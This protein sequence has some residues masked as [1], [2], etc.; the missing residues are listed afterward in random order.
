MPKKVGILVGSLRKDSFTR[1]VAEATAK[2]FPE[3]VQ[4]EFVEIGHLPF[5]NQDFETPDTAPE[6]HTAFR[7]KIEGYDGFLFATP[8]YNR[9]H[10][11]VLKNAIDIASR[12]YG[13]NKWNGQPF[14]LVSVSIGAIGGFGANH[15]LRQ[16]FAFLI[17]VPAQQPEAYIGNVSSLLGDAGLLPEDSIALLLSLV[18]ALVAKL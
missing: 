11:P 10:T 8:E 7:K 6:S 3:G 14:A 17:M 9:S 2:L 1:K 18:D 15:H 5:F 13:E 4:A 16:S 12:P